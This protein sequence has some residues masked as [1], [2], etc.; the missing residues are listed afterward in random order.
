[1]KDPRFRK[2]AEV[3]IN[4]STNLQPGENI[5]IEAIDIPDHLVKALIQVAV[6]R[7]AKPYVWVKQN[8]ILREL[9]HNASTEQLKLF[10]ENELAL[11][12]QM[13]AYVGIRG[14]N[15]IN[16][17]S[18]VP[19]DKMKLYQDYILKPVHF[20]PAFLCLFDT[21]TDFRV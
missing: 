11:M 18:D 3:L 7:N 21:S 6:E 15:N 8:R 12:K 19:V 20:E 14:A 16:E 2:L 9:L 5:L 10:G 4:Y 1:M 17:L 13:D